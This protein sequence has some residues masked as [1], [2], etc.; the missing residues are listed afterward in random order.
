MERFKNRHLQDVHFDRILQL[1]LDIPNE[2]QILTHMYMYRCRILGH[3]ENPKI[4]KMGEYKNLSTGY[5]IV[6]GPR[7][8]LRPAN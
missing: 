3:R 5:R 4:R 2:L 7:T 6:S 1:N 8:L